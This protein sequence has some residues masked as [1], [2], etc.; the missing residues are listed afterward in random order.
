MKTATPKRGV[1]ECRWCGEALAPEEKANPCKDTPEPICC[2]C[3]MDEFW[4]TCCWCCEHEHNDH[5]H[6]Y[7]VVF[8]E[9]GVAPGFYKVVRTP[10]YTQAMIGGGWIC[11]YAVKRIGPVPP[12]LAATDQHFPCGHLCCQCVKKAKKTTT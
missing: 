6:K 1:V 12:D 2:S 8:V 10:Y 4:F 11:D 5:Q 9:S 7:V 3:E